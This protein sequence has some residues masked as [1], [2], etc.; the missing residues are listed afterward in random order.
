MRRKALV[1][2]FVALIVGSF[3]IAWGLP[4]LSEWVVSD[5]S[6]G[7][8]SRA[9]MVCLAFGGIIVLLAAAVIGSGRRIARYGKEAVTVGRFPPPGMPVFRDGVALTGRP[10]VILGRFYQSI[11]IT[12]AVLGVALLGLGGYAVV[13][14]WP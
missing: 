13:L 8:V 2:V 1:I 14:L 7:R 6:P 10:A 4:A 5:T 11:G 3:A 9:R 12:L